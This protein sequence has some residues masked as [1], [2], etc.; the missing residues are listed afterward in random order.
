VTAVGTPRHPNAP[1][2]RKEH[3]LMATA[4]HVIEDIVHDVISIRYLDGGLS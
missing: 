1:A 4:N 3:R 2:R